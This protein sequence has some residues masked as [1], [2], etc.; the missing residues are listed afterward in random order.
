[1]DGVRFTV[2]VAGEDLEEL[3]LLEKVSGWIPRSLD[4]VR[5][6]M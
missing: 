5:K 4:C 2:V 6:V 1:M 3:R